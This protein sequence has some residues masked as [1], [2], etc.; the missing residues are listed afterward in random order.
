MPRVVVYVGPVRVS[1]WI[2]R[3]LP[4]GRSDLSSETRLQTAWVSLGTQMWVRS[5]EH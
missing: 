5:L 3:E 1:S 4:C 2:I